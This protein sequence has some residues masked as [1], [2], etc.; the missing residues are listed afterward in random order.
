MYTDVITVDKEGKK[1]KFYN[2]N[3][4]GKFDNSIKDL[5]TQNQEII[6]DVRL[7]PIVKNS[8]KND[9]FVISYIKGES[10]K[11]FIRGYH[12]VENEWKGIE[13][14]EFEVTQ[15]G[16]DIQEPFNF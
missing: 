14:A 2:Y 7:M 9:L 16:A 4:D 6:Q 8:I 1:L 15:E 11:T 13:G 3:E 10:V 5:M 12:L